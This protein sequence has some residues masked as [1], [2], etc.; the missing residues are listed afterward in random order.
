MF[1]GEL[2]MARPLRNLLRAHFKTL[3]VA[4]PFRAARRPLAGLKAC[5]TKGRRQFDMH[6]KFA[7]SQQPFNSK[8]RRAVVLFFRAT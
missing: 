6:S 5:P 3:N 4:Q 1:A 8:G 2:V 7:D